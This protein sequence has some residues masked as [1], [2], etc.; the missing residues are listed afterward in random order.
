[1]KRLLVSIPD[2]SW[3][4]IEKKLKGRLGDKDS[5]VVRNIVLSYLS[6]KGY[7]KDES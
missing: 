2:G 6:E 5:E 1:M 3:R 4:I 7:I